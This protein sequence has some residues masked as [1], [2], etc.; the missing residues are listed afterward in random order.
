[1]MNPDSNIAEQLASA[2]SH[3]QNNLKDKKD[4]EKKVDMLQQ[5]LAQIEA[6]LEKDKEGSSS[7]PGAD[8]AVAVAGSRKS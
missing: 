4:A 2:F 6:V 5:M 8:T 3:H 1:M 7:T